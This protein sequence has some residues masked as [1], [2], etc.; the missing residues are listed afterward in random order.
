MDGALDVLPEQTALAYEQ[1]HQGWDGKL[2]KQ[3]TILEQS[4]PLSFEVLGYSAVSQTPE[5]YRELFFVLYFFL[6][7]SEKL[8]VTS[9]GG[10]RLINF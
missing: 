6:L 9:W 10:M 8:I 3:I 7:M 1:F 5:F 2:S 4:N